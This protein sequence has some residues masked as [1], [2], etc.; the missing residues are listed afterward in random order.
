MRPRHLLMISA[1][2]TQ[3]SSVYAAAAASERDVL[4][5][6][7]ERAVRDLSWRIIS[8]KATEDAPAT[9]PYVSRD[10]LVSTLRRSY[11]AKVVG[12]FLLC[13][14]TDGSWAWYC[15]PALMRSGDKIDAM[16]CYNRD[17]IE[18]EEWQPS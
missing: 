9:G 1:L 4:T 15:H 5:S 6:D 2:N 7:E 10:E 11:F 13:E 18:F 17:T 8:L 16:M 14:N 3:I 12:T